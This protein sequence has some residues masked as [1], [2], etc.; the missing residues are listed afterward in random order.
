LWTML[1]DFVATGEWL[2]TEPHARDQPTER[3]F[4]RAAVVAI[5]QACIDEADTWLGTQHDT[6]LPQA[7]DRPH[8][9]ALLDVVAHAIALATTSD[10]RGPGND[11]LDHSLPGLEE[12]SQQRWT[13]FRQTARTEITSGS[14]GDTAS[15]REGRPWLD[16]APAALLPLARVAL[17]RAEAALREQMDRTADLE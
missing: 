11:Q 3:A 1:P 16:A 6:R 8:L 9:V 13:S 12:T 7:Q 4:R 14:R 17:A 10:A 15:W 5:A 2:Y